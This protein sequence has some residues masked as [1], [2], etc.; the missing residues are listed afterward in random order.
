MA[1]DTAT[2]ADPST[3]LKAVVIVSDELLTAAQTALF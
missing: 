3:A 2:M 1:N